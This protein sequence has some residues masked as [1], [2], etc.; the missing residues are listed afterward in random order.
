MPDWDHG[1]VKI[2]LRLVLVAVLGIALLVGGLFFFLGPIVKVGL[3]T[4]GSQALGVGTPVESVSI[5]PIAGSVDLR[6]LLVQS[7]EGFQQ[8][9]VMRLGR[10]SMHVPM[11]SLRDDPL[12]IEKVEIGD[13]ALVLERQGKA[14]NYEPLLASAKRLRGEPGAK[15]QPAPE[16]QEPGPSRRMLFKEITIDG[17]DLTVDVF[18]GALPPQTLALGRYTLRDVEVGGDADPFGELLARLLDGVVEYGLEEAQGLL[19]AD[20]A[21]ILGDAQGQLEA[22]LADELEKAED[23][24]QKELDG[25]AKDLGEKVDG[26]LGD[27]LGGKDQGAGAGGGAAEGAKQEAKKL[28]DEAKKKLG[29]ILGGAKDGS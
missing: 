28:G 26:V 22:R 6:G 16:G 5:S 11:A 1:R 23:R 3:E 21:A 20:V 8:P 17:V 10:A 7:P 12:V 14:F 24:L 18:G 27:L 9:H 13:F 2:L 15:D 19:P 4:G 25:A 29:G